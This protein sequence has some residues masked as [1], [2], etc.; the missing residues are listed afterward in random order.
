M[1][2][3][4]AIAIESELERPP[5]MHEAPPDTSCWVAE[6]AVWGDEPSSPVLSVTCRPSP[7]AFAA[8]LAS[9]TA[10]RAALSQDGPNTAAGPVSGTMSPI[11]RES[12]PPLLLP[13]L[14]LPPPL[15]LCELLL[16]PHAA[17]PSA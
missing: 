11:F 10:R 15:L 17:S 13:P 2:T 14:L 12:D 16:P 3:P 1:V 6:V 9:A 7:A 8:L 5:R 4:L